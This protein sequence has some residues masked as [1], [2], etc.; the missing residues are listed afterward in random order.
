MN[1]QLM[2][3]AQQLSDLKNRQAEIQEHIEATLDDIYGNIRELSDRKAQIAEEIEDNLANAEEAE[4]EA[5]SD[6]RNTEVEIRAV[7]T[8]IKQ[9]VY[10]LPIDDLKTGMKMQVGSTKLVVSKATT[11]SRYDVEGLLAKYPEIETMD[12]DGD[13]II[14]REV[15]ES[16]MERALD[17]GRLNTEDVE[18][19]RIVVKAKNPA[20]RSS[21]QQEK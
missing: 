19:F 2:Q 5:F 16:L 21:E 11:T 9:A 4:P 15:D 13:P 14:V 1:E 20:V 3:L 8:A 7:E 12:I 10:S 17:S 18:E 6:L